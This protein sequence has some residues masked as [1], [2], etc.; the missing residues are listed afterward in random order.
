MHAV[1]YGYAPDSFNDIWRKNQDRELGI[2]LR[3]DEFYT[4]PA[5]RCDLFKKIPIYSLP[6]E[7]NNLGDLTQQQNHITLIRALKDLLFNEI[8]GE[9]I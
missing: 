9:V 6:F 1:T 5:P 7:W 4:L 3:N 2:A 8:L